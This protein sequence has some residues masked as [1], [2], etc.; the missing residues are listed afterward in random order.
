MKQL[1]WHH[2]NDGTYHDD[3][4]LFEIEQDGHWWKLTRGSTRPGGNSY[5]GHYKTVEL[6]QLGA[7]TKFYDLYRRYS[8]DDDVV[9]PN[10]QH[11][12]IGDRV[13]VSRSYEHYAEWRDFVMMIVGVKLDPADLTISYETAAYRRPP[14]HPGYSESAVWDD[15]TTDW[16]PEDLWLIREDE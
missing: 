12:K 5:A 3:E 2:C 9:D 8:R 13:T 1:I 11:F 6:A 15:H 14:A 10:V 7:N 16:K 4:C